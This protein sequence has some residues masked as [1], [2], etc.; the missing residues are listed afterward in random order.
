M[1]P[2]TSFRQSLSSILS[3]RTFMEAVSPPSSDL[4]QRAGQPAE[5]AREQ[6]QQNGMPPADPF[7][8]PGAEERPARD[9][10]AVDEERAP[11]P[12]E[13]GRRRRRSH[14]QRESE[15]PAERGSQA[16]SRALGIIAE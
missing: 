14:E 13:H 11:H 5:D 3:Q 8:D 12:L 4:C 6:S 1:I 2:R 15:P 16:L 9:E 10:V 7:V